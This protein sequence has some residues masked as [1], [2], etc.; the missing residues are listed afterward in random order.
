[1]RLQRIVGKRT[2]P[3]APKKTTESVML[4]LFAN[5]TSDACAADA[6]ACVFP[7]LHFGGQKPPVELKG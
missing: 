7:A 2:I 6:Y 5:V 4:T 1:M 3:E